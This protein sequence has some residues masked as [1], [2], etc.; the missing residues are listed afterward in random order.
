MPGRDASSGR[1]WPHAAHAVAAAAALLS[2]RRCAWDGLP[3]GPPTPTHP[4]THPAA[5]Q[6]VALKKIPQKPRND[7][8]L[9]IP[10]PHAIYAVDNAE[11]CLFVKDHKGRSS[12]GLLRRGQPGCTHAAAMLTAP[13]EPAGLLQAR[14]T[15]RQR[16]RCRRSAWPA[17][18]RCAASCASS[19]PLMC[20]GC[21]WSE[22][23]RTQAQCAG[24]PA[25]WARDACVAFL[26]QNFPSC[27]TGGGAEQAADQVRKPR[28]QAAAMQQL[29]PVCGR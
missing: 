12:C 26:M 11:V 10:I 13:V 3:P 27:P 4:P 18:P 19:C 9:R 7:K 25:P 21:L 20:A 16:A 8:P 5:W 22:K 29:R 15:R 1:Q 17:S 14:G 24:A 2:P 28:G 23:P 6:V